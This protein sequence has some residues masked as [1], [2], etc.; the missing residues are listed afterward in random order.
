MTDDAWFGVTPEPVAYKIAEHL[1]KTTPSHITT[2]IDIFGGAAGNTIAF[3]LSN[4]WTHIYSI[5]RDL[6]VFQCARA[7]ATVY[8]VSD[9]ITFIHGDSFDL[10]SHFSMSPPDQSSSPPQLANISPENTI[11]FASP[12]WGG[13]D[14]SMSKVY[15]LQTMQPYSLSDLVG[16]CGRFSHALFL[17][18]T[19]NLN[20]ISEIVD[21]KQEK[22]EV[23]VYCMEGAAKGLVA[24]LPGRG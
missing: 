15:D 16:L 6:S 12:P 13:S 21:E 14:Y 4:R 1:V 11:I 23:V 24:Y 10:L 3:A 20:Q 8:G 7:N 18:R 17:P 9:R 22:V 5:E 19:A 2:I